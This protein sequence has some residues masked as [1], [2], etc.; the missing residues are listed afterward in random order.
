MSSQ[1]TK[2]EDFYC[3]FVFSGK[4]NVNKVRET[5]NVLAF[6]HTKPFWT[7]HIVVV[8]KQHLVNLTDASDNLIT[9]IFSVIKTI[10]RDMNLNDSN[11]R[12]ITNGGEFQD[13]KHLHFH[14][15]SGSP[16]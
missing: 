5:D 4:V 8:P 3:D 12:V 14:I 10:I 15:L 2:T 9:E 6:H 1:E 16:V 13:S 11:F 7:T